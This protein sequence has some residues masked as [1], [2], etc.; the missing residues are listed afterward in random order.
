MKQETGKENTGKYIE[1]ERDNMN[2]QPKR[3][4]LGAY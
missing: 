2:I 1:S 3:R 4:A